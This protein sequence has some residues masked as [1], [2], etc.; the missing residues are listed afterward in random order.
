MQYVERKYYIQ[1]LEYYC[2]FT[3]HLENTFILHIR[4]FLYFFFVVLKRIQYKHTLKRIAFEMKNKNRK[5]NIEDKK[6]KN[7]ECQ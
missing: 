2:R 3:W 4:I 7:A 5:T 1:M 6:Y